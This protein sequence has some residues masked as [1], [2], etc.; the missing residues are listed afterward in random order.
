MNVIVWWSGLWSLNVSLK[1]VSNKIYIQFY[2]RIMSI[3]ACV[4]SKEMKIIRCFN[5][6][7]KWLNSYF[8][9]TQNSFKL[10]RYFQSFEVEESQWWTNCIFI[11]SIER[12]GCLYYNSVHKN[13]TIQSTQAYCTVYCITSSMKT[14]YWTVMN[15][16]WCN[17]RLC[18]LYSGALY[19]PAARVYPPTHVTT[20]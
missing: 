13:C 9:Q 6:R 18:I 5:A 11:D 10:K 12:I 17:T 4:S 3:G 20:L 16:K 14:N 15:K 8:V 7:C 2:L 1:K 19:L